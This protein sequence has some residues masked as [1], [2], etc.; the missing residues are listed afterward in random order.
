MVMI[1]DLNNVFKKYVAIFLNE[2]KDFLSKD[3][4]ETLKNINYDKAI[5]IDDIESPFGC[6]SLG[7]I[8]LSN[9][10]EKIINNMKNM[11]DFNSKHTILHNK[12]ISSYLKYMCDNGYSTLDY[13][14]DILMYFVFDLVIKNKSG[15]IDGLINQEVEYL[16]IKYSLRM[17][18]LYAKEE[19][20]VKKIT[21]IIGLDGSRKVLFSDRATSFKYL[22]DTK[23]FRVANLFSDIYDLMENEY[24]KLSEREYFGYEGFLD[25]AHDYDH[26]SYGDVYNCL[27]DYEVENS[28][29]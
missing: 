2:Y 22:N 11:K 5:I 3:Q 13:Y 24:S 18:S 15:L 14:S 9:T 17:A 1:D 16:S 28:L 7:Q 23:G 10:S 20:I 29:T 8:H 6:I 21:P 27:L 12:N 26:L 19:A 25:Y 4:L